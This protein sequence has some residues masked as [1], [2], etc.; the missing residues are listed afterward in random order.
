M[1]Q[2]LDMLSTMRKDNVGYDLKQLFIGSEGSLGV[3][4]V[5]T[6]NSLFPARPCTPPPVLCTTS[7]LP[8]APSSSPWTSRVGCRTLPFSYR[9]PL[10][11]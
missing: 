5:R 3:V 1:G 11:P 7:P 8:P 10:L 4:T 6:T 2:V 9:K